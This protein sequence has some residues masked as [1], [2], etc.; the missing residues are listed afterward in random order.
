[1]QHKTSRLNRTSI[2]ILI[3]IGIWVAGVIIDR[4]WFFLDHSVPAWD[5]AD[6]LNGAMNYWRALQNPDW[7]NGN[8]WHQLWLLSSKI[9]PGTYILTAPFLQIFGTTSDAATA[10]LSVFSAVLLFSIYGLGVQLFNPK[11]GIIAAGFCQILPGLYRYR[12]DFVLDYPVT[13]IVALSFFCLTLW[14]Q[15]AC[16]VNK[17]SRRSWLWAILTGVALGVALM[18]KQ[19]VVLFLL[20][21][22]LLLVGITIRQRKWQNLVQIGLGFITSLL[23]FFP[24]YRTN[25]LLILTSGKR[26]TVDSA[27]AEGDPALTTI[28]A[29]VYYGKILPYLLSWPL[30]IIPIV[31]F[32]IYGTKW[33]AKQNR[34]DEEQQKTIRWLSVFIIGSYLLNSL[35][36]NKDARYIL[37]LLPILSL[38]LAQGL[39]LWRRKWQPYILASSF[40]LGIILMIFNLFPLK[41]DMMTQFLS[42]RMQH[43]PVMG[44]DYPHEEVIAEMVET[45]PYLRS[46]LGVLPSTPT[47]N[48][49][50]FSFYGAKANFQ[51]YG[52]QVGVK[53]SNIE[54]DTRSL[55]WFLT[56]TGEQGSV[57]EAQ[58]LITERVENHD[59]FSV[60]KQW[61]LPDKSFLKLHRRHNETVNVS[62][63]NKSPS[64]IEL[65]NLKVPKTIPPGV[66][67]PV[68]YTWEGS[69]EE[70]QQGVVLLT[71]QGENDFWLHDHG[72]AM[73]RLTTNFPTKSGFQVKENTAM[74]PP[75]KTAEGNYTL[76]ARYVNRET[77]ESYPLATPSLSVTVDAT[78]TSP[79]APELDLVTQLRREAVK[80]PQG[81][82]ALEG[83]FAEISQINQYDPIQDYLRQAET[84]F[85]YRLQHQEMR[86]D[87]L[88][89]LA[90][91]EVLQRD[92]EGAIAQFEEITQL[93]SQNP[94]AYAYLAFVYLY[95]WQPSSAEAVLNTA[96]NLNPNLEILQTLDGVAALMQGNLIQAYQQLIANNN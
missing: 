76:E 39:L 44:K 48:Q 34:F 94:Y 82:K 36:L 88:Y 11:V 35:N 31:A 18:I 16:D 85:K 62:T 53:E 21:P 57:P 9:P 3:L 69:W 75:P 12:T 24:W 4:A 15:S 80:L 66:P 96:L 38:I 41:G 83:I 33:L 51:V 47:I 30:L 71:W 65:T 78:A 55:S 72:I 59:Q 91:S 86:L 7:F 32:L 50:N 43:H 58:K 45:S 49:H 22:I 13:A 14:K 63:I 84:A 73:G 56:K 20:L 1:M 87:W 60:K 77:G 92:V 26:A 54:Q 81:E 79:D 17:P 46:T 27:I 10:I 68:D 95:N 28:D 42:P 93:D 90:L 2:S 37:P 23:I 89:P 64:N 19:T 5:Q 67:I 8:W 29:W 25:W 40:G 6:Y 61:E 52:R 70:L 74:L